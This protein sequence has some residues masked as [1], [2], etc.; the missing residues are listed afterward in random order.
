MKHRIVLF[1]LLSI[2]LLTAACGGEAATSDTPPAA[3]ELTELTT[4]E[5]AAFEAALDS[6][7]VPSTAPQESGA[8]CEPFFR[9]CVTSTLTGAVEATATA[10]MGGNVANCAAWAAPGE[11]RILELPM[12]QAAGESLIT[13]A[14][15]RV[16]AYTGPG[17]YE[18]AVVATQGMPDMFPAIAA[19]GRT[20]SH[21][22]G[23]RAVVTIAADG[24]GSVA[25]NDLVEIAS[26]QVTDPDPDARIDFTMQWTCQ[27]N[28]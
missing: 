14:L 5:A 21:G 4:E 16:G 6:A 28:G 9:F 13:V 23:S 26:V 27:E 17:E 8:G 22:D 11:A 3:T 18:L 24:S 15:T 19:A 10:G 2:A 25:A 12:M 7:A 20:F 1:L